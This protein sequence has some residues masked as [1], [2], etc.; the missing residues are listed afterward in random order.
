[1]EEDMKRL[2]LTVVALGLPIASVAQEFPTKPIRFV[3]PYPPGG[4]S[5]ITA[6]VL[7]Q[8]MGEAWNQQ[9]V[10]DNRPG[11]NG[12][13]A[14]EFVAKAPPDGYT[15][16][17][18]NLGPN[19]INP[20]VYSKLPYDAV[21][22]FAPVT[23][24]TIVPQVIVANTFLPASNVRQ[25]VALAKA[26]PGEL[27]YGT[28]GNG[29]SNHLAMELLASMAGVRMT[30]IAYKGDA[31]AM[32]DAVAGQVML[33]LPTVL[34]A[35]P[36]LNSGKLKAIA[37]TPKKRV[38]ALANVPTVAESGVPGLADYESVSWGG[39]MAP[40]GTPAPVIQKLNGELVRILK[41]PD[42]RERMT[43]LGADIVAGSPA[44]FAAYLQEEITKWGKVAKQAGVR[45]D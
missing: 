19:A 44:E 8:K 10:V 37:V 31:P 42:V 26:K 38:A 25:L 4:A 29:S 36:F 43:G 24:T 27:T 41:L 30:M 5:D 7:G 11:A 21:K 39:V 20:G 1:M 22:S 13:I 45:L 3:V 23:L 18:A 2:L 35:L 9:V 34:A 17:M 33:A 15:I 14:L 28:G 16:L 12:I 32:T 6:R 40:A